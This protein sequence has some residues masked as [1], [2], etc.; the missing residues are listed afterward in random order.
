MHP[1]HTQTHIYIFLCHGYAPNYLPSPLCQ[2]TYPVPGP[3][4]VANNVAVAAPPM[5][6]TDVYASGTFM[7]TDGNEGRGCG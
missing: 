1:L 3:L 7:V 2:W 4:A 5:M 6:C